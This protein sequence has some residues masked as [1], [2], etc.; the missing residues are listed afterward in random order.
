MCLCQKAHQS[1]S[2]VEVTCFL[3]SALDIR[4]HSQIGKGGGPKHARPAACIMHLPNGDHNGRKSSQCLLPVSVVWQWLKFRLLL[5]NLLI[6]SLYTHY[7]SIKYILKI[8]WKQKANGEQCQH[9]SEMYKILQLHCTGL[10][11]ALFKIKLD[12]G[13]NSPSFA[14]NISFKSIPKDSDSKGYENLN[15]MQLNSDRRTSLRNLLL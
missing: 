10:F 15:S 13:I 6:H 3:F 2:A 7:L 1:L 12:V 11:Q 9:L 5:W 4:R 8:T 14:L